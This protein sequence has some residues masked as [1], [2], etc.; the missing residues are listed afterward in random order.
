MYETISKFGTHEPLQ[1]TG[2]SLHSRSVREIVCSN[3]D[4]LEH[5]KYEER[6]LLYVR[7]REK[8]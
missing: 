6:S 3:Y 2:I 7:V 4:I 1:G 5:I 8:K